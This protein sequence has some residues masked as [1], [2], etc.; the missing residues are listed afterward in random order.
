FTPETGMLRSTHIAIDPR[1][2]GPAIDTDWRTSDPAFFA[3]GNVL[4]PVEHSGKAAEEGRL[5]AAAIL[6]ALDG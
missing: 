4:R 3:A 6:Q 2:G 1:T 5:A